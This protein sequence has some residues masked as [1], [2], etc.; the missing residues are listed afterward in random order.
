MKILL[1]THPH[2]VLEKREMLVNAIEMQ[3]NLLHTYIHGKWMMIYTVKYK[4][5]HILKV[6]CTNCV[7]YSF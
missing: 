2:T 5:H 3:A 1:L 7:P 4:K 6:I